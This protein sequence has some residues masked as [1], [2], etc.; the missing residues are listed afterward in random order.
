MPDLV[1]ANAIMLQALVSM[2]EVLGKKGLDA[3]L[4]AA[5][6]AQYIDNFPPNDPEPAISFAD[7]ARL[8]QAVEEYIGRAS[9]GIL[10]R[11]GRASFQYGRREQ[12]ALLGLVGAALK[13]LPKR[14]QVRFILNAIGNALK[15][16]SPGT[17]F[18]VDDRS[19]SLAYCARE[20]S[21]C[22]GRRSETA[23]G[24]LMVGSLSEAVKW[25][26]GEELQ[27]TETM[28]KARGDAYGRWEVNI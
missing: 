21:I 24:H 18:W 9:K 20:C 12:A 27:V 10:M 17:E 19:D 5:H 6:L 2:E 4:N 11:I 14:Q 23:V 25:V 28:C 15:K 22:E 16:T 3:V 1:I 7:Y 8:N 26:T 13:V